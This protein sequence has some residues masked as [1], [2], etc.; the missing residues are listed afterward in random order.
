MKNKLLL[1][2]A[3]LLIA[4]ALLY[5]EYRKLKDFKIS[6]NKI[7]MKDISATNISI[8]ATFNFT[9]KSIY[10]FTLVEQIYEVYF[11]DVQIAHIQ[12]NDQSIVYPKTTSLLPVNIQSNPS[13]LK[14][15][16]NLVSILKPS[17]V[18]RIETKLKVNFHGIMF[19]V[20]FTYSTKI[21]DLLTKKDS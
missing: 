8:D 15:K 19:D 2:G 4:G 21:G 5:E 11:N 20:P 17:S 18:L 13:S 1:I 16:L 12:S 9:N 14:G 3:G 10:K 6:L 7:K